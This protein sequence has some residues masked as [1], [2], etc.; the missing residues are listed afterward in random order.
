M[1]VKL[2]NAGNLKN[3]E[4]SVAWRQGEADL[5]KAAEDSLDA[6]VEKVRAT[7]QVRP[8]PRIPPH[9]GSC[10]FQFLVCSSGAVR[11]RRSTDSL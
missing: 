6:E 5:R 1:F 4:V 9:L 11:S 3:G 10:R 2:R 7:E 8:P